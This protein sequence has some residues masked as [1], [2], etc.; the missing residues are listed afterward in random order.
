[1]GNKCRYKTNVYNIVF[2]LQVFSK[3]TFIAFE[4]DIIVESCFYG[5]MKSFLS[6]NKTLTF[7]DDDL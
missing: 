7:H 2:R 4:I 1:M 3:V 6:G 5:S